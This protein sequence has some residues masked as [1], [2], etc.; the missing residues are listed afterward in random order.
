MNITRPGFSLV[1]VLV[2]LVMVSITITSL[3]SLQGM[4]SKIVY[5]DS[6]QW[7]A[8]QLAVQML[9]DSDRKEPLE[10]GASFEQEQ[11]GFKGKYT[12]SKP[13]EKSPLG[14]IK[15]LYSEKVTV[16]WTRLGVP[17]DFTLVRF[18]YRPKPSSAE[19]TA[20]HA[21]S[22]EKPAKATT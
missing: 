16:S 8:E 6:M 17:Q 19:A 12:I 10:P 11:D 15:D 9:A 18:S 21:R 22:A 13:Q 2:A 7:K 3:L 1:E 14:D 20:G 5:K 4:L